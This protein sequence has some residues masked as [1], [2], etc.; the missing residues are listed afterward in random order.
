MKACTF[1]LESPLS[2]E[3][4]G[5]S[6]E[7]TISPQDREKVQWWLDV[8]QRNQDSETKLRALAEVG[9][10]AVRT[11][12][13]PMA[14]GTLDQAAEARL[15]EAQALTEALAELSGEDERIRAEVAFAVGEWGDGAAVEVLS[16]MAKDPEAR[17]RLAAV[18]ALSKIGGPSAVQVLMEVARGDADELV[19]GR[20]VDGLRD[21][22]ARE[23]EEELRTVEP[24]RTQG[25][26][27][28]R[29]D[30]LRTQGAVRTRGDS[31]PAPS[32]QELKELLE[33]LRKQDRSGYVR[34]RAEGFLR[35]LTE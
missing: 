34:L 23:Q 32:G 24:Q 16:C 3:G 31:P 1:L 12:G 26:I 11:R 29:G 18:G 5:I 8:L 19:W 7:A 33:Q 35:E 28:A 27:R 30:P 6:M 21:L 25:T 4:G 14:R 17:V 15:P 13:A 9:W 10:M 20:A 2:N 22:H